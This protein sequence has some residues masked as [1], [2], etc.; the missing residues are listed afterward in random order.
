MAKKSQKTQAQKAVTAS[1]NKKQNAKKKV[2]GTVQ[3]KPASQIPVRLITS[4]AFVGLFILFAIILFACEGAL[5]K[6]V[7]KLIHGFIGRVGFV[8]SIPVLLY[9]FIIHAFSGKRPVAMRTFC[10]VTF[11]I[12]CAC[13][14]HL[15]DVPDTLPKGLAILSE[16][17][18]NGI[19][20]MNG[21]V[22]GGLIAI[23]LKWLCGRILP[24]ILLVLLA[25]IA[26]LGGMDITIPRLVK[27][28]HERPRAEWEEE[29]KNLP[30]E[31]STAVVN[32]IATKRIEYLEQRRQREAEKA[33]RAEEEAKRQAA[34]E[35]AR[36]RKPLT[37]AEDIM[38]Q[39][40]SDVEDPVAVSGVAKDN[41]DDVELIPIVNRVPE[42]APVEPI[43]EP[44]VEP[45]VTEL[46]PEEI[47]EQM[48]PLEV[49]EAV[50][51]KTPPAE[52]PLQEPVFLFFLP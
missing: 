38:S 20:G 8:I 27:A 35:A 14:S 47:P 13:I 1:K 50:V 48:P 10:L 19:N 3:E 2:N 29:E 7:E 16:L 25:M 23:G 28:Y 9:L 49:N 40:G 32:H 44:V 6:F 42:T 41:I 36:N 46:D 12:L 26:L 21:G 4:A 15:N 34:E 22:I 18:K 17:Y 45:V 33:A 37:K 11:V 52:P 51:Q 39:I 5:L 24:Y 31:P 43:I 30:E